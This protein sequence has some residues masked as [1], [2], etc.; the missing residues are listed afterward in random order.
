MRILCLVLC[1]LSPLLSSCTDS[2]A[3]STASGPFMDVPHEVVSDG[4]QLGIKNQQL[5]VIS[6]DAQLASFAA[7]ASF[8]P[9]IPAIDLAAND[10]IA[11][12]TG[13]L[14]CG[15]LH[16]NNVSENADTLL[17]EIDKTVPGPGVA[18]AAV[19][20]ETGPYILVTVPKRG[21][22]VSFAFAVKIV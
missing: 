9:A 16:L 7:T 2:S 11:I 17:V 14:G 8:T 20:L 10:V 21:K 3:S 1:I 13:F 18:C 22:P 15:G 6:N 5:Q 4:L 12:A 19:V